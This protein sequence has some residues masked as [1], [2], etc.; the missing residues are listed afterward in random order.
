MS[1]Y[2]ADLCYDTGI[3]KEHLMNRYAIDFDKIVETKPGHDK[4]SLCGYYRDNCLRWGSSQFDKL[5]RGPECKFTHKLHFGWAVCQE[6][7]EN[8][9]A[10]LDKWRTQNQSGE[11][12]ILRRKLDEMNSVCENSVSAADLI[13]ALSRLPP[14]ARVTCCYQDSEDGTSY[15]QP[16]LQPDKCVVEDLEY[17]TI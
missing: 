2:T 15:Q 9:G 17:Y 10:N 8:N 16:E 6:C 7:F 11:N 12:Y 13:A 3:K 4:C 1:R 5:L 14:D